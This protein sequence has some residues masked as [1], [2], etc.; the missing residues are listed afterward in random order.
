MIYSTGREK[1]SDVERWYSV[2]EI[3]KHIGISRETILVWVKKNTIPYYKVGRQYKFKIT[4]V[5]NWI[6]SGQSA[7]ADRENKMEDK[8]DVN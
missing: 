5:D 6:E 8:R 7:N 2:D 4:E 1:M 3:S